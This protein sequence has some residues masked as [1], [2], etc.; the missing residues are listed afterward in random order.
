MILDLRRNL[1]SRNLE[2]ALYYQRPYTTEGWSRRLEEEGLVVDLSKVGWVEPDAMIRILLL[3]EGVLLDT[4]ADVSVRLPRTEP[5]SAERRKLG[6][7]ERSGASEAALTEARYVAASIERQRKAAVVIERFHF[8]EAL[9]H[10]HLR[11]QEGRLSVITDHDWSEET[12]RPNGAGTPAEDFE[13]AADD[14]HD[15][16]S[17]GMADD[18]D[19]MEHTVWYFDETW[20]FPLRWIG[21]PTTS[22]SQSIIQALAAEQT[23]LLECTLRHGSGRVR[24]SDARMLAYVFLKELAANV[25]EHARRDYALLAAWVRPQGIELRGNE[26]LDCE[27]PFAAWARSYPLVELAIGDSGRGVPE[28]LATTHDGQKPIPDPNGLCTVNDQVAAWAFDKWSTSARH[29][30]CRG[31]KRGTRGLYRV[32]RIVSKYSGIVTLRTET[33]LVGYDYGGFGV[34]GAEEEARRPGKTIAESL[35]RSALA[36][37]RGTVIHARIPVMPAAKHLEAALFRGGSAPN[38][39]V[40]DLSG[41]DG[42]AK[43]VKDVCDSVAAASGEGICTIVDFGFRPMH[44]DV[45]SDVLLNLMRVAHP[46][47][48]VVTN[49][50]DDQ[51][52]NVLDDIL[53]KLR[54]ADH[55]EAEGDGAKGDVV[56]VRQPDRSYCWIGIPRGVTP[57]STDPLEEQDD[58]F[59]L[60]LSARGGV[61][62]DEV[63]Q[64]FPEAD[65][66]DRVVGL[67]RECDHVL[68]VTN[69]GFGLA[70]SH[71]SIDDRLRE[72]DIE[73]TRDAGARLG[74]E[75]QRLSKE[76]FGAPPRI[77]RTPSLGLVK[78]FASLDYVFESLDDRQ[79]NH[80][81]DLQVALGLARLSRDT[82]RL[83]QPS[84]SGEP[85]APPPVIEVIADSR[86]PSRLV[87]AYG[88]CL[89]RM[90]HGYPVQVIVTRLGPFDKPQFQDDSAVILFADV[91]QSQSTVKRLLSQAVRGR[92]LPS[93]IA[94]LVDARGRPHGP[95]D[96]YDQQLQLVSLS[97]LATSYAGEVTETEIVNIGPED[98]RAEPAAGSRTDT[99]Q[100][101]EPVLDEWLEKT[102]AVYWGH[103]ATPAGRH[104][105][106][107]VDVSRLLGRLTPTPYGE[108][109]IGEF[110]TAIADWLRG[111]PLDAV[112]YPA[113][114]TSSASRKIAQRLAAVFTAGPQRIGAQ[115]LYP[116]WT[117]LDLPQSITAASPPL[118][119]FDPQPAEAQLPRVAFERV[120]I[121]DWGSVTERRIRDLVSLVAGA[122][123]EVLVVVLLSQG[124]SEE[125][126]SLGLLSEV[127]RNGSAE[128]DNHRC[129]VTIKFLSRLRMPTFD[130]ANCPL[131]MQSDRL[132]V[133]R[134]FHPA[135]L[136]EDYIAD[137]NDR[138]TLWD[139]D[140]YRRSFSGTSRDE[141]RRIL[142]MVRLR[143]RIEDAAESTRGRHRLYV[144]LQALAGVGPLADS[145]T[146]EKRRLLARL[147]AAEWTLLKRP[148]FNLLR[149]K[150]LLSQ[151][152]AEIIA[153]GPGCGDEDEEARRNAIIV[154]RVASKTEFARRLPTLLAALLP[155]G[156]ERLRLVWQL[157]YCAFTYLQRD[158]QVSATLSGLVKALEQCEAQTDEFVRVA[159][160]PARLEVARTVRVLSQ[161]ARDQQNRLARNEMRR[162]PGSLRPRHVAARWRELHDEVR[163]N[164]DLMQFH[165]R[166]SA[167]VSALGGL[168]FGPVVARVRRRDDD[169]RFWKERL[170]RW[171]TASGVISRIRPLL[172]ENESL[173]AE[174]EDVDKQDRDILLSEGPD[175]TTLMASIGYYLILFAQS[176]STKRNDAIWSKFTEAVDRL[177]RL[178]FDRGRYDGTLIGGSALAR[179]VCTCPTD[180]RAHV[181]AS[182]ADLRSHLGVASDAGLDGCPDLT[183]ER[184]GL[185]GGPG[186]DCEAAH[187]QQ[188]IKVFCHEHLV[189]HYIAELL[190]NILTHNAPPS[191]G[192]PLRAVIDAEEH[193]ERADD[194]TDERLVYVTIR[195]NGTKRD[196]KPVGLT[197]VGLDLMEQRLAPYGVVVDRN[198]KV[199]RG[200]RYEIQLRF[201]KW[202]G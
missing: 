50:R 33:S 44:P 128:E 178:A 53:Y 160:G 3:I 58:I 46:G 15:A 190:L 184:T 85:P 95:L 198:R 137:V 30:E 32:R 22:D 83:F 45:V 202:E 70:F 82:L 113:G 112:C 76:L 74:R 86:V 132:E 10:E 181:P 20:V 114:D 67:L 17:Q 110:Q 169:P 200:W 96:Y 173:L 24:G 84:P 177:W 41:W 39:K 102:G 5:T 14:R 37:S 71:Q 126:L 146:L 150:E 29:D 98:F 161:Y 140:S 87:F 116:N 21:N 179:L 94:C 42:Q 170:A 138:L 168:R 141:A 92:R 119:L 81:L 109:V 196:K 68:R 147:L 90:L 191:A 1:C 105:M 69:E 97:Q 52:G 89:E 77:C 62:L 131:C 199:T 25:A 194:G 139:L 23:R 143:S 16:E 72:L 27:R 165:H 108:K 127:W 11:L 73:R 40:C 66:Q 56:L 106:A 144:V 171:N 18:P 121:V 152:A 2:K 49:L 26:I 145:E 192:R 93:A 174:F 101:P 124:E 120:A 7:A 80:N 13:A 47:M 125:E 201:R 91:I 185:L 75:M 63:A 115:A 159:E 180:L 166:P 57:E 48:L 175:L 99:Y 38:F 157:L 187:Q 117:P 64:R 43:T 34:E 154:L 79:P 142:A 19:P 60:L 54:T 36:R 193:T 167:I 55:L 59:S 100:I 135:G 189:G 133:E 148:P 155:S 78:A 4:G 164:L 65:A 111:R 103:I 136:F 163:T 35:H 186:R 129:R 162:F 9:T 6:L 134:A 51:D 182:L 183:I 176:P 130:R 12:G 28:V 158:Y 61:T 122:A 172:L 195:N 188:P 118:G 123:K 156:P 153:S 31:P 149:F 197:G 104:F 8:R 107:Y 88:E 151:V